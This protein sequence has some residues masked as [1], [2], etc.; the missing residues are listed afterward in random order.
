MPLSHADR[1][2]RRK[3]MADRVKAGEV[4]ETVAK[5]FG[6]Q[7]STVRAA[8]RE[9]K[10][11]IPRRKEG[12]I[13]RKRLAERVDAGKSPK[14]VAKEFDVSLITV[15]QACQENKVK[16]P[17]QKKRKRLL[18]NIAESVRAGD[19][20][21]RV[22]KQFEVSDW[23]VRMACREHQVK[24][25]GSKRDGSMPTVADTTLEIIAEIL[26]GKTQAQI[27]KQYDCTKAW[28]SFVKRRAEVAG[29]LDVANYNA[30][31]A[32]R[33]E[34]QH[35]KS[36]ATKAKAAEIAAKK[37]EKRAKELEKQSRARARRD[38]KIVKHFMKHD[39]VRA[40]AEKYGVSTK[41]VYKICRPGKRSMSAETVVQVIRHLHD[42]FS[43]A[44][45][46]EKVGVSDAVARRVRAIAKKEGML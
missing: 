44:V 6:V 8:C 14:Q 18:K 25:P 26:S 38:A 1:A 13:R 29:I 5:Q 35:A 30:A 32:G 19:P 31:L 21:G 33:R 39:N 41:L 43:A 34:Q 40:T 22:A 15:R 28:V 2:T 37:R 45:A 11:K 24:I 42:G 3:K 4:T 20:P 10:V 16:T 12:V 9:H 23:T 7:P 27:A 36:A 46:A 17:R